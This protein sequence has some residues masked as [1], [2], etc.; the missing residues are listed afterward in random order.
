M[1]WATAPTMASAA[2]PTA[3]T[4]LATMPAVP[5]TPFNVLVNFRRALSSTEKPRLTRN[6]L[7]TSLL[8]LAILLCP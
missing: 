5:P 6:D 4:V 8:P 2:T 7:I 1:L 3:S